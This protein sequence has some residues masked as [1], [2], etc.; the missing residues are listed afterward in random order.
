MTQRFL[1]IFFLL[2]HCIHAFAQQRPQQYAPEGRFLQDTV[3]V[4]E[5]IRYAVV[6]KHLP[7]QEAIFPD[8]TYDFKPFELR[9][10]LFFPT[11]TAALSTD[12]VVYELAT[13]ELDTVQRFALPVYVLNEKDTTTLRTKVDSIYLQPTVAQLPEQIQVVENAA[14]VNIPDEFNYP[15]WVAGVVILGVVG[16]VLFVL[17]GGR[18]R[19]R[20][21]INR[22]RKQYERFIAEYEKTVEKYTDLTVTEKG[23]KIWKDYLENLQDIPFSSYTSK[24]IANII[25]DTKLND[26]LKNLDRAIYG[27]RVNELLKDS[28]L[29]L[30]TYA[31][32]AYELKLKEVQ[33]A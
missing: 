33:N 2:T 18:I 17:F 5:V 10:K 8:S 25:P 30:R 7:Q 31:Q 29:V 22:M 26:A 4:G 13:F 3:K 21:R 23:L 1:L 27:Q 11:R 6:W 20:F 16:T 9:N 14:F 28:L 19:K 15:Y 32:E 24:E 12:S